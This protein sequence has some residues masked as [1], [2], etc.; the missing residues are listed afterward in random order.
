[1]PSEDDKIKADNR[2]VNIIT[3]KESHQFPLYDPSCAHAGY[4]FLADC[5][6][7]GCP[8]LITTRN[9]YIWVCEGGWS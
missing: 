3:G 1:M 8:I 5:R 4:D 7:D 6:R 2:L 9:V